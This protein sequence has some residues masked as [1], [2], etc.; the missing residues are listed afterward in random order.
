MT[1]RMLGSKRYWRGRSVGG[2]KTGAGHQRMTIEVCSNA[3]SSF[4]RL[5]VPSTRLQ[6]SHASRPSASSAK[7]W[8]EV[9]IALSFAG[10]RYTSRSRSPSRLT[11]RDGLSQQHVGVGHALKAKAIP[12]RAHSALSGRERMLRLDPSDPSAPHSETQ[13][14]LGLSMEK[15]DD[16]A[17]DLFRGADRYRPA[18]DA[19]KRSRYE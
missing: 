3:T 13:T 12:H 19:S 11:V 15:A 5:P 6:S 4:S 8:R 16:C 2:V 1:R 17:E 7:C 9:S 14:S 18:Y 10:S